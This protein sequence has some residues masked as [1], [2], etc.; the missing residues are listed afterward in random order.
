MCNQI[1]L[2]L[3]HRYVL[4][5]C[6][7]CILVASRCVS[8]DRTLSFLLLIC[9]KLRSR[10]LFA[11]QK[12]PARP[13]DSSNTYEKLNFVNLKSRQ[14][15][16]LQG[17]FLVSHVPLWTCTI[18]DTD[19]SAGHVTLQLTISHQSYNSMRGSAEVWR[20]TFTGDHPEQCNWSVRRE[21]KQ[22]TEG[23]DPDLCATIRTCG[24]ILESFMKIQNSSCWYPWTSEHFWAYLFFWNTNEDRD[25][26]KDFDP[27][28]SLLR[29]IIKTFC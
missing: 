14:I 23:Q 17:P 6:D 21:S 18:S 7:Q 15:Q 2:L 28:R 9:I 3:K 5:F 19:V 27:Q 13:V 4:L 11:N 25:G 12:R 22:S 24:T 1:Y 8:S 16:Q 26:M 20:S 29:T 10:L